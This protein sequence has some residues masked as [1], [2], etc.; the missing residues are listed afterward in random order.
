[1]DPRLREL[2]DVCQV[3]LN[4]D[5]VDEAP[6]RGRLRRAYDT[7]R[8][9][10]PSGCNCNPNNCGC[11]NDSGLSSTQRALRD[12][13]TSPLEPEDMAEFCEECEE[14]TVINSKCAECGEEYDDR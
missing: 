10:Q 4:D 6:W 12:T 14:F 11:N 2:L 13:V 1:M 8:N 9:G 3:V 7:M 5:C